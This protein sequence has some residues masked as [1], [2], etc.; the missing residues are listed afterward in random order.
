MSWNGVITDDSQPNGSRAIASL[1][2]FFIRNIFRNFVKKPAKV[3][4]PCK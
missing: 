4:R 3:N 1:R 2:I